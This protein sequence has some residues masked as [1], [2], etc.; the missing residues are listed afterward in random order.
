MA[1]NSIEQNIINAVNNILDENSLTITR[2]FVG[3]ADTLGEQYHWWIACQKNFKDSPPPTKKQIQK[4]KEFF[5]REAVTDVIKSDLDH[6][7]ENL[8]RSVDDEAL[9]E[10][11]TAL[12]DFFLSLGGWWKR[13]QEILK[14]KP[15]SEKHLKRYKRDEIKNA[16][17]EPDKLENLPIKELNIPDSEPSSPIQREDN[18]KELNN[19]L[20]EQIKRA[21]VLLE[22][23]PYR[24]DII[25]AIVLPEKDDEE[26]SEK[27]D[28]ADDWLPDLLKR[29]NEFEDPT[30]QQIL[31]EIQEYFP[32]FKEVP[33]ELNLSFTKGLNN[34][35][36]TSIDKALAYLFNKEYNPTIEEGTIIKRGNSKGYW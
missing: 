29:F 3:A 6:Q 20:Q 10:A 35:N 36:K 16:K 2:E 31:R 22:L 28:S 9:I 30:H 27:L 11:F 32:D 21:D 34:I 4:V 15:L 23:Y 7:E 5:E 1:E 19:L 13:E 17:G 33:N 25:N 14:T 12:S 18:R 8:I 26:K 24:H